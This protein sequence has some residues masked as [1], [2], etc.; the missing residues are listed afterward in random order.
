MDALLEQDQVT[1]AIVRPAMVLVLDLEA[2]RQ[3]ALA[4]D[5]IEAPLCRHQLHDDAMG[6]MAEE[7]AGGPAAE[8]A[9]GGEG[10]AR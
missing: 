5:G 7:R 2:G 6:V 4:V 10:G 3:A 8:I 9:F 1:G